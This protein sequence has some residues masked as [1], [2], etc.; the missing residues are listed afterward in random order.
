V[1]TA[2]SKTTIEEKIVSALTSAEVT[3]GT[4][5]F[6]IL[7]VLTQSQFPRG[8]LLALKGLNEANYLVK[9]LVGTP[10]RFGCLKKGECDAVPLA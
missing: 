1:E 7:N 2:L 3:S 6:C 10:L 4:L 9:E 8:K 5:V